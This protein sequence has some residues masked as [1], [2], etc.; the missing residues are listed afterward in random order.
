MLVYSLE[1]MYFCTQTNMKYD[2]EK[3]NRIS[4]G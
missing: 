2:A 3:K 4:F 1:K